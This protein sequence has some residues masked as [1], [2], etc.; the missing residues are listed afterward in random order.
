MIVLIV[1]D[2]DVAA[3]KLKRQAPVAADPNSPAASQLALQAVQA[4]AGDVHIVYRLGGIQGC[5]LQAQAWRMAGLNA[6]PAP[7]LVEP[8]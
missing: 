8:L 2:M 7:R 6:S 1:Q 3:G 4:I 5:E